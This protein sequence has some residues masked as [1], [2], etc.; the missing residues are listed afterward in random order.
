MRPRPPQNVAASVRQRLLN[1]P[2]ERGEEFQFV[3]NRYASE[4]LL[5][6][7]SLSPYSNEFLLK[8]ATLFAV[9]KGEAHRP[10]LD[11]DLE[12]WGE[13]APEY[14]QRVFQDL[15]AIESAEDGLTFDPASLRIQAMKELQRYPGFR[16]HLTAFLANAKIPLQI[17]IGYGDAI[18]PGPVEVQYPT[19]LDHPAPVLQVYPMETVVAEK[20]Q[21]MVVLGMVNTRMK[22]F[23]D[24]WVLARGFEFQGADL[25]RAIGATFERRQT[26]IP[27]EAPVAFRTEF[28]EDAGKVRDWKAFI[29]RSRLLEEPP[30]LSDVCGFLDGFLMPPSQ[31]A[32]SG[33]AFRARWAPPGP[34]ALS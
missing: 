14:L 28:H 13:R 18:V 5:H 6:R 27:T 17:D 11:L 33:A 26:P 9:W 25:S 29:R 15:C 12:A 23:Y 22:D 10:T 7:L 32:L 4:R 1:L 24:L 34:W 20:F 3:L 30:A 2:R 16:V 31:A 19:L 21:A 8:G